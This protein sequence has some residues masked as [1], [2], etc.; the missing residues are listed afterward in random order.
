V[1]GA[2][3]LARSRDVRWILLTLLAACA[4]PAPPVIANT[5]PADTCDAVAPALAR[6]AP[7]T[8]G[9]SLAVELAYRTALERACRRD[10]WSARAITCVVDDG[11]RTCRRTLPRADRVELDAALV[12]AQRA[13]ARAM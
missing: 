2:V 11:P 8:T 4:R 13:I 1:E 5:L 7:P 12:D 10:G 3:G 6:A 9:R